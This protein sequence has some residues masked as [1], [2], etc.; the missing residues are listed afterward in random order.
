MHF[1]QRNTPVFV[2]G[3]GD[4]GYLNVLKNAK[5][6]T[7]RTVPATR[8]TFTSATLNS[9][10]NPNVLP[11]SISFEYGLTTAYGN[12]IS[13]PGL[14][15]GDA[16][17]FRKVNITGLIPHRTYH[18]RVRATNAMGTTNGANM[19]FITGGA[20]SALSNIGTHTI[21]LDSSGIVYAFGTNAFGQLGDGTNTQRIV[22]I[23]VLKGAY[24]GTTYLGD[25]PSNPIVMVRQGQLHSLALAADGTVYS[26]GYNFDGQL[27]NG[28]NANSNLPIKVIK[29]AYAGSTF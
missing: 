5:T 1:T 16:D 14:L 26:F 13:I 17:S 12:I 20:S 22:P 23:K 24:N 9:V 11:T 4:T 2:H 28:T 10:V 25:N 18:Y 7:I 19:T 27:G 8:V 29:G 21:I 3:V 6:P 15:T